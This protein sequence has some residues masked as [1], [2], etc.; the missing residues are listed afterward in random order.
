MSDGQ[1]KIVACI[2]FEK[3]VLEGSEITMRQFTTLVIREGFWGTLRTEEVRGTVT[4]DHFP[5]GLVH[6]P[7]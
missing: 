3:G 2:P 7:A 4:L 5:D 1:E 6:S